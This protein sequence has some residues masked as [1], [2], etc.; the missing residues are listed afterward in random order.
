MCITPR[1][2]RQLQQRDSHYEIISNGTFLMATYNG[3]SERFLVSTALKNTAAPK[4]VLIGG[5]GVGF[6]L[7]EALRHEQITQVT[8]IEIEEVII[9]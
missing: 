5:L 1:G 2:D 7:T 6:S 4:S 9:T 3:E 8:V